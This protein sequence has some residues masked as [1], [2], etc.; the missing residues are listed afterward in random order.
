MENIGAWRLYMS[1]YHNLTLRHFQVVL[2][3]YFVIARDLGSIYSTT[4]T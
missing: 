4:V 1:Q 3:V 2:V